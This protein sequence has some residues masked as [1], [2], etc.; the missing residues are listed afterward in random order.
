MPMQETAMLIHLHQNVDRSDAGSQHLVQLIGF[1]AD[2]PIVAVVLQYCSGGTLLQR[3]D[4]TN[5]FSA[6]YRVAAGCTN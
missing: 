5:I 1:C 2:V 4:V 3:Y 6:H